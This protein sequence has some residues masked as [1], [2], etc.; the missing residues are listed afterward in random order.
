ME[1]IHQKKTKR[2]RKTESEKSPLQ[3]ICW[4]WRIISPVFL[5]KKRGLKGIISQQWKC[6]AGQSFESRNGAVWRWHACATPRGRER[7]SNS[8]RTQ[9]K[10]EAVYF[11]FVCYIP[12]GQY[13]ASVTH[14]GLAADSIASLFIWPHRILLSVRKPVATICFN[15]LKS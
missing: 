12:V 9:D 3:Y 2:R 5:L 6:L 10:R 1:I 14:L 13:L 7:E 4:P 15:G 8:G 11:R